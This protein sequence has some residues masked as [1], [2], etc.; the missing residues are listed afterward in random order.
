[1]VSHGRVNGR[2][3]GRPRQDG[4]HPVSLGMTPQNKGLIP[5]H[6]TKNT[7][8]SNT[9]FE[10]LH[11]RYTHT[12][13]EMHSKLALQD[14]CLPTP[15]VTSPGGVCIMGLKQEKPKDK[16]AEGR[17]PCRGKKGHRKKAAVVL[18][19]IFLSLCGDSFVKR[20]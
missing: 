19:K 2:Q 5:T 18:G 7:T 3:Y 16:E 12:F 1:M 14:R 6:N 13:L 8:G 20:K 10:K 15:T 9:I 4:R 11:N 17:K